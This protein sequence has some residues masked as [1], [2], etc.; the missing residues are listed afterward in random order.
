VAVGAAVTVAVGAAVTVAVGAAV[1]VAAGRSPP[2]QPVSAAAR[3]TRV[4][5]EM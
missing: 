5:C 3:A 2:P 1:A 4:K